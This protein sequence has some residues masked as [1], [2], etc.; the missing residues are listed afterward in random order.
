[1][2]HSLSSGWTRPASLPRGWR[3]AL[4]QLPPAL[5]VVARV[6]LRL[7]L[8]SLA[9]VRRTMLPG[10]PPDRSVDLVAVARIAWAVRVAAWLVPFA[11][12][13]TQAQA[14]QILLA[15]HGMASTL[16]LG[17]RDT[18]A[19]QIRAHAWLYCANAIVVGGDGGAIA[20]FQPIAQLPPVA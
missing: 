10:A 4:R 15:R 6:R 5:A 18:A 2:L 11:S 12:C 13:L 9:H 1:M 8:A 17:V 16:C 3:A 14:C 7:T 20:R 19:G